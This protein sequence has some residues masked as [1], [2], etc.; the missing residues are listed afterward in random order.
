MK[1]F[2]LVAVVISMVVVATPTYADHMPPNGYFND[3]DGNIHEDSINALRA[4]G[5]TVGCNPPDNT[6]FCPNASVTRA[7][8]ATFLVR[9]L[10]L[11]STS[12]D[13]FDDD[14]E[15]V[16]EADINA[17]RSA[18]ITSGCSADGTRYC[19]EQSVSRGQMAAFLRR[20][21]GIAP[22]TVDYFTDDNASIFENDINA[23]AEAGIT[24]G[25]GEGI[26]C[27]TRS[28]SRAEMATFLTRAI[29]LSIPIKHD[30]LLFALPFSGVCGSQQ[31]VCALT[32][33]TPQ[34]DEHFID[35]GW[36]YAGSFEP[37]EE[38][39]FNDATFT[40]TVDGAAVALD[41]G[42]NVATSTGF[43]RSYT[44]T[45]PGLP[46]G[47]HVLVGRWIWDG[48]VLYST[49]LTVVVEP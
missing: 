37:G 4:S 8:M 22:T 46:A 26:F 2:L 5:I 30:T 33:N 20:G 36:Y 7:Q 45:L 3:D 29:P 44:K 32:L 39:L 48:E 16:H 19:P 35:E 10:G 15:S 11:P 40:L 43:S 34:L 6:Q 28:V 38:A 18:G 41:E 13:Y 12:A 49:T 31:L 17:L 27:A 9:A 42:P 21:F 14:G 24:V 1:Q 47:T 23:I 25:C